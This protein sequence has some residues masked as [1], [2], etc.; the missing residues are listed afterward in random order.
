MR[1]ERR[2]SRREGDTAVAVVV[3]CDRLLLFACSN[4]MS[5]NAC[6]KRRKE[7]SCRQTFN[8]VYVYVCVQNAYM[9]ER[10]SPVV[11]VYSRRC[12]RGLADVLL[13]CCCSSRCCA[14][15]F[16]HLSALAAERHNTYANNTRILYTHSN[17]WMEQRKY[18]Q[19]GLRK[20]KTNSII[21]VDEDEL[22]AYFNSIYITVILNCEFVYVS[23]M[24]NA[25]AMCVLCY[26]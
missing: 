4:Q 17:I 13:L 22:N 10:C 24:Q 15:W 12:A 14:R 20:L 5:T 23:R 19:M 3:T 26:T 8:E 11:V 25:Y 6:M 9:S 1:I 2:H 21:H 18:K 7:S 16:Y